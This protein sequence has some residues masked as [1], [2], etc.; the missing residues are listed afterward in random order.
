LFCYSGIGG[1]G[2]SEKSSVS[3]GATSFRKGGLGGVGRICEF[4]AFEYLLFLD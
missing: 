4:G 2:G 1:V 3:F